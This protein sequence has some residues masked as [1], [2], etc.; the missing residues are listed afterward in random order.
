MCTHFPI[1]SNEKTDKWKKEEVEEGPKRK[2]KKATKMQ[3]TI[4]QKQI[5][6]C[7]KSSVQRST[8]KAILLLSSLPS[9]FFFYYLVTFWSLF[10]SILLLLFLFTFYSLFFHLVEF[11]MKFSRIYYT[12]HRYIPFMVLVKSFVVCLS[13][14]YGSVIVGC[15]F[16]PLYDLALLLLLP[17]LDSD[18]TLFQTSLA[19]SINDK[20]VSSPLKPNDCCCCS[21]NLS[22]RATASS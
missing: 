21:F 10:H 15:S 20:T 2:Q 8:I 18:D 13:F 22:T 9:S 3:H 16:H 17:L 5:L 7:N 4:E 12:L 14:G 11:S 6:L 19:V 1:K